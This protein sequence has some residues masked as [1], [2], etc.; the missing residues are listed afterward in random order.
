MVAKNWLNKALINPG[1][2]VVCMEVKINEQPHFIFWVIVH[3]Y[4]PPLSLLADI[5]SPIRFIFQPHF[6]SL[7]LSSKLL[8]IEASARRQLTFFVFLPSWF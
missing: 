4:S 3:A 7:G 8:Y 1:S 5:E 2:L 6:I